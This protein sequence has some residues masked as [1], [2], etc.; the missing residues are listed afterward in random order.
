MVVDDDVA[1]LRALTDALG[2][3]AEL[4]AFTNVRAAL[5]ALSQALPDLLLLD[6]TLPDG[7]AFTVLEALR[8][9]E[10]RPL[11]IAISGTASAPQ[12]FRL[13]EL[14]VNGFLPKPFGLVELEAAIAEAATQRPDIRP[15]LRTLVGQRPIHEIEREVRATML[16]E[17]LA[18]TDGNR[19]GAARLL[20][21]SRQLVQRMIRTRS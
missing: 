13:A 19:R 16:D 17:A 14:G 12:S 10:P 15:Q 21:V 7:D 11:V 5:A 20:D 1:L 9:R 2:P 8:E 4:R 3:T 6:V 18:R